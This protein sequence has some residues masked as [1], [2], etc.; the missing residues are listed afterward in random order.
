MQ[1]SRDAGLGDEVK[2]RIL[3]GTY[4]LRSGF[5]DQY[6]HRAQKIRTAIRND[7]DKIFS[8]VD[9]LL[10]PVFPTPAFQHGEGGLDPFQQKV[11]DKFTATANLAGIPALAFPVDVCDG[12]PVGMQLMAP[13]FCEKRLFSVVSGL[14]KTGPPA[15]CPRKIK[16]ED[17]A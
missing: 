10:S 16:P 6:Y 11:A 12:L 5:Q 9:A 8:E 1:K 14:E 4:V 2:L 15:C 7:L 3:L 17:Q 13:P